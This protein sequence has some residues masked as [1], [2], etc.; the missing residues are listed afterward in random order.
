[1]LN[2][3][4]LRHVNAPEGAAANDLEWELDT[5]ALEQDRAGD[6]VFPL[7]TNVREFLAL[8][9]LLAYKRQPVIEKRF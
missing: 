9:T 5:E 1:M 2:S 4:S 3:A 6:G 8:D 7:V